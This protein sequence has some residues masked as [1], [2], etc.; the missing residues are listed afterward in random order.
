MKQTFYLV[1]VNREYK[2]MDG[3]YTASPLCTDKKDAE[4][5]LS[6][7]FDKLSDEFSGFEGWE[8][9]RDD[10]T[11]TCIDYHNYNL[12]GWVEEIEVENDFTGHRFAF[13]IFSTSHIDGADDNDELDV[14]IVFSD[15]QS[16]RGDVEREIKKIVDRY[17]KE[18]PTATWGQTS[19]YKFSQT[20][21]LMANFETDVEEGELNI[22]F[23]MHDII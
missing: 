20:W 4:N 21:E 10:E 17:K 7:E 15:R 12:W 1:V 8:V 23:E 19:D 9:E 18:Y 3:Y 5:F 2:G 6:K 16:Y 13:T 14:Q 22:W 11:F